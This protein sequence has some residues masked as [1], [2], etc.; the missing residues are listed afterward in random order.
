MNEVVSDF[1]LT[2]SVSVNSSV[3]LTL[4]ATLENGSGYQESIFGSLR[5]TLDVPDEFAHQDAVLLVDSD[6]SLDEGFLVPSSNVGPKSN[7]LGITELAWSDCF[8]CNSMAG[9]CTCISPGTSPYD[10]LHYFRNRTIA[11]TLTANQD[12]VFVAGVQ[13][14]YTDNMF[15]SQQTVSCPSLDKCVDFTINLDPALLNLPIASVSTLQLKDLGFVQGSSSNS[16][17]VGT[18]FL[19]LLNVGQS[20]LT[21][22]TSIENCVN[23]SSSIEFDISLSNTVVPSVL[24]PG[25]EGY[26]S[27][28]VEFDGLSLVG[29]CSLR[30][31]V[32]NGSAMFST[33]PFVLVQTPAAPALP[34]DLQK[35]Y[36]IDF[37]VVLKSF[38]YGSFID[39]AFDRAAFLSSFQYRA[40]GFAHCAVSSVH[41]TGIREG[42]VILDIKFLDVPLT[43]ASTTTFSSGLEDFF[44]HQSDAYLGPPGSIA[45][46]NLT[47]QLAVSTPPLPT[48]GPSAQVNYNVSSPLLCR[49]TLQ[50]SQM[51]SN[52]ATAV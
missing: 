2:S 23:A 3:L 30:T 28:P 36:V 7:Q 47:L 24:L 31:V 45:I 33:I 39:Q 49:G 46:S 22:D 27:V 44:N 32:Q 35:L 15:P 52:T 38:T 18:F 25:V 4:S 8:R 11:K 16:I 37:S 14:S 26:V 21:I 6:N 20:E 19:R 41:V 40:A 34:P 17:I 9:A 13:N 48:A 5:M 10:Q 12:C 43:L 42:S 1:S 50:F 51:R 29:S